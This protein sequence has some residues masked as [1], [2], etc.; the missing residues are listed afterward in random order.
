ML[1]DP[2]RAT[3][4]SIPPWSYAIVAMLSVQLGS[5]RSV[6]LIAEIGAAGTA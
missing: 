5:A 2:N 3:P 1:R 4:L 6:D